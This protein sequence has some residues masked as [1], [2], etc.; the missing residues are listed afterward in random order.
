M[1]ISSQ[2][3]IF[4]TCKALKTTNAYGTHG[5]APRESPTT[6]PDA[7]RFRSLKDSSGKVVPR[8]ADEARGD[9]VWNP[10]EHRPTRPSAGMAASGAA[11]DP[12]EPKTTVGRTPVLKKESKVAELDLIEHLLR[13][14]GWE[15]LGAVRK[16]GG[17]RVAVSV[18]LFVPS[19]D[20]ADHEIVGKLIFRPTICDQLQARIE[21]VFRYRW[22]PMRPMYS[23]LLLRV[24]P[25]QIP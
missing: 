9:N 7:L 13:T 21:G 25:F 18:G 14:R 16:A 15:E 5:R 17:I 2:A 23:D 6:H 10:P 8:D 19:P 22:S 24:R 11:S 4:V 20:F 3:N 12:A 1:N